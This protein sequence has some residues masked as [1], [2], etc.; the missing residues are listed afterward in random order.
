MADDK[1]LEELQPEQ[2]V[3]LNAWKAGRKP[4]P[5]S[6]KK[7]ERYGTDESLVG[8]KLQLRADPRVDLAERD[9]HAYKKFAEIVGGKEG[10]KELA[11]WSENPKAQ[12]L[13]SVLDDE[14]YKTYGIK[15]LSKRCGMTLPEL[16]NLFREKH[17]LEMYL[18]F[19]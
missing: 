1:I 3:R 19:F 4:N 10:L 9:D 12:K 2:A 16:C 15:A 6:K 18:T 5:N 13:F 11:A 14:R 8:G 7:R 17:F